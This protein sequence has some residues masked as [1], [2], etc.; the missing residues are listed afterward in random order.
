MFY[1]AFGEQSTNYFKREEGNNF[2]FP[3]HLHICYELIIL[4]EGEMLVTID[5]TPY[6]LKKNDAV[7][8]FPNQIH[9]LESAASKHIL[10]LFSPKLVQAYTLEKQ[11][12][13]PEN[14]IMH[15]NEN[16]MNCIFSL[17][18]NSS[19]FEIKGALYTICGHFDNVSSYKP[20][21]TDKNNLLS[22]IFTFVEE[23]FNKD[24]SLNKLSQITGYEYTYL[25]R[26]FKRFT[27]LSYIQYVNMTRLNH[28]GYLLHNTDISILEISIECG[29]SS[30]RSFN[31]N[32]K[33]HYGT[34]PQKYKKSSHYAHHQA[35]EGHLFRHLRSE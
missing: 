18:E 10:F 8:V 23:N 33:D 7:L 5:K 12:L 30:L 13:I 31:R 11:G 4:L 24:C 6:T 20:A 35:F 19:K 17:N 25:S 34:T 2:S 29:Y 1:Q 14:N 15:F 27:G 21:Y 32:F 22:K 16:I 9:S 28:A 3:Q 26:L